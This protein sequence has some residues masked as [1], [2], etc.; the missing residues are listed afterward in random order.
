MLYLIA[1]ASLVAAVLGFLLAHFFAQRVKRGALKGGFVY[2][3]SAVVTI[4]MLQLVPLIFGSSSDPTASRF[5]V[6]DSF[7][8]VVCL[9]MLCFSYF[10]LKR[11]ERE[12]K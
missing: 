7:A 9:L 5:L 2:A 10:G 11:Q 8:F 4:L 1:F 12:V 3:A 6:V